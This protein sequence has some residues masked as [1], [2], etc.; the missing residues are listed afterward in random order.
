[1]CDTGSRTRDSSV[2]AKS[3]AAEIRKPP[4]E[5]RNPKLI[6]A[7]RG[8]R[9]IAVALVLR[10]TVRMGEREDGEGVTVGKLRIVHDATVGG[11]DPEESAVHGIAEMSE[12][13]IGAGARGVEVA[14]VARQLVAAQQHVDLPRLG[15]EVRAL[16]LPP[17]PRPGDVRLQEARLRRRYRQPV[18]E[19]AVDQRL[20][21]PRHVRLERAVGKEIATRETRGGDQPERAADM[22]SIGSHCDIEGIAAH[23]S[24]RETSAKQVL[25]C[26]NGCTSDTIVYRTWQAHSSIN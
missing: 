12:Q 17:L 24:N 2:T 23:R 19:M 1:M 18:R 25:S 13:K 8:K 21:V 9:R 15:D 16:L 11:D 7:P 10:H 26:T 20:L 5:S 14:R 6:V 4:V 22:R 3:R